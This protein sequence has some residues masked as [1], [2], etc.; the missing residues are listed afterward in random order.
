MSA[1]DEARPPGGAPARAPAGGAPSHEPPTPDRLA[2]SAGVVG[3]AT[4]ASRLLG[5]VREQV[6]AY[7][8][9]ASDAYDA[10]LV[11][12]RVPN[13]VR[14]LFAEGAMSAAFVPTFSRTL[15]QGGRERAWRLGNSVVNALIGVTGLLVLAGI[16]FAPAL[17]GLY[18]ADFAA[19]P[20]KFELTVQLTRVMAPFLTLVA[21][22]AAFMGM[23][24]SL[25]RFFVPA[26][27]PAMFNVGSILTILALV[28]VAHATG[29]PPV[30]A[31][32]AGTLVGG[33]GQV[34]IQWPPLRREGYR[35]R[36]AIDVRDEALHRVLV[37]MGP[38][39]LGL[40]ATQINIFVNTLLAT[41]EGTGAVSWL[42][43]AFRL[44]YLPIGLFG[45]SIATAATPTMSRLAA[46]GSLP[47]MRATIA[48][49]ISLMLALN[50][51][52]T[53][54]LAVLAPSIVALIYEHGRFTP[55]DTAA[56]AAALQ[57]Y[58]L[59]L[60]G[61]SVVKIVSPAFYAIGRSRVPVAVSAASVVVNVALN[62]A[63]VRV[64]GYRGLALGTSIAALLNAGALLWMLGRA[65]DG[66]E[67]RRIAST[68]ARI[69][70]ASLLM[71]VAAWGVDAW[72]RSVLPVHGVLPSLARVAA[73]M[74]AGIAVLAAASHGLGVQEFHEAT[75]MVL[76]RLRRARGG[77][78]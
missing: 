16:A 58:A 14:D 35:Y 55:A 2:R 30:F 69:A 72:L 71:G 4:M 27:S 50:V 17:V 24:N 68:F 1:A 51:P 60:V 13:L 52:A 66:I 48:S 3:L 31:L 9:G 78:A 67:A 76:R 45:V 25:H 61:Y 56:T 43:Y 11:A 70:V 75:A 6:L 20:G 49:G 38:G 36:P 34:L 19:V 73:A 54:G 23:L 29:V 33:L 40:A 15:A 18:A 26:L 77:P 53:V 64:L 65:L 5:L 28:P 57:Y 46:E 47:T 37:L 62:V 8:F 41:G 39:T 22:A 74:S 21:L 59:G 10:F 12:F 32:A 42:N 63:L 7:Y 44:M